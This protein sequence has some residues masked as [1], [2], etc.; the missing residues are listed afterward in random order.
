VNSF[1]FEGVVP[2]RIRF[3]TTRTAMVRRVLRLSPPT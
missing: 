2:R 3:A 1:R